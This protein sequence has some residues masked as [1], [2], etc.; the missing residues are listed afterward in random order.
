MIPRETTISNP[1]VEE[2]FHREVCISV[3]VDHPNL[4]KTID[5]AVTKNNYYI[6]YEFCNKGSLE[7][8]VNEKGGFLKEKMQF[9][10]SKT[11]ARDTA[12]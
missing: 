6:I 1:K 10:S 9:R 8:Y 11:F 12:I 7:K 5:F 2:Q 4:V 3:T